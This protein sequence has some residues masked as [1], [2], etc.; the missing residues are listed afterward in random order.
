MQ[1]GSAAGLDVVATVIAASSGGDAANP[2]SL[3]VGLRWGL[4]ACVGFA[5]L[6][7]PIV[8]LGLSKGAPSGGRGA[9][10]GKDESRS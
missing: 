9:G 4:L 7:L 2:E 3:V 1:L 8:L 6:A 5:G 10:D